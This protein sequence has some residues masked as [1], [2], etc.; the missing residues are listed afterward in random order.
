MRSASAQ[1]SLCIFLYPSI[2][3]VQVKK[4][5][6]SKTRNRTCKYILPSGHINMIKVGNY[7]PANVTPFECRFGGGPIVSVWFAAFLTHMLYV[8]IS[9]GPK[10]E[11]D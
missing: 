6:R 11:K 4:K 5:T 3:C 1:M 7:R 9:Y 10:C 8:P 2:N